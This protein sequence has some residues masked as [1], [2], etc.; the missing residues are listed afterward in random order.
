MTSTTLFCMPNFGARRIK[1]LF[2]DWADLKLTRPIPKSNF[3]FFFIVN[4][5][6]YHLVYF[7]LK[8]LHSYSLLRYFYW[9]LLTFDVFF[10]TFDRD[11][12]GRILTYGLS[13]VDVTRSHHAH[14]LFFAIHDLS[15][16]IQKYTSYFR[17]IFYLY[18]FIDRL[19]NMEICKK[20]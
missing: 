6:V 20:Y 8:M 11:Y 19:Q 7:V 18:N 4:E 2:W 15:K 16:V 9:V 13:H 1:K 10:R 14:V 5:D 12:M 3:I 17:H